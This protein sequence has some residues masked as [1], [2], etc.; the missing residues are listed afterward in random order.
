[1][2]RWL[3][4]PTVMGIL[5]TIALLGL[6][7]EFQTPG[8]WLPGLIAVICF[9]IIVG[10]KFL[11]GMANWVEVALFITGLLL[12]FVEIF[13]DTWFWFCGVYR[14]NFYSGRIIRDADKEPA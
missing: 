4:S 3:N 6:Y 7:I 11:I 8:V 14:D 10:S 2:V 9:I 1:M 5:V 12:L 13:I